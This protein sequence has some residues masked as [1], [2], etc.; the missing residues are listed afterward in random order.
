MRSVT[1]HLTSSAVWAD[2]LFVS[3]LQ[4]S[5]EPSPG[6]VRQAIAAAIR[7]LGRQGCA[8][9]VAQEY[10]EHPETACQRMRW[11]RA[12]IADAFGDR[13]PGSPGVTPPPGVMSSGVISPPGSPA[14]MSSSGVAPPDGCTKA[15][16]S[17]AA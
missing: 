13:E 5:Q 11:A 9:R 16:G 6:Q 2:A 4:R 1:H 12:T 7:A 3:T 17:R 15:C 8:G 14:V 10:G